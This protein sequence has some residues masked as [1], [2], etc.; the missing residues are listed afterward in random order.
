MENR[1]RVCFC[2][3]AAGA[4][5]LT[6]PSAFPAR[7]EACVPLHFLHA[8]DHREPRGTAFLQERV[9]RSGTA[10][11]RHR[12]ASWKQKSAGRSLLA[13]PAS[14]RGCVLAAG[15]KWRRNVTGARRAACW[16]RLGASR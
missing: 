4:K 6:R 7:T 16:R 13:L 12:A 15:R 8:Q 10:R 1:A 5:P 2:G 11:R 3:A 9:S 14:S